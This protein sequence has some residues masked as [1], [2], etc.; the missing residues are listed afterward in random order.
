MGLT[1]FELGEIIGLSAYTISTWERGHHIPIKH[2]D[3]LSKAFNLPI[4]AI[5]WDVSSDHREINYIEDPSCFKAGKDIRPQIECF[6]GN[7]DFWRVSS[8]IMLRCAC[9]TADKYGLLTGRNYLCTHWYN[10]GLSYS[11]VLSVLPDDGVVWKN[12]MS[13][14]I[15]RGI[16]TEQVCTELGID[17][18]VWE[19]YEKGLR[20]IPLKHLALFSDLCGISADRLV[21]KK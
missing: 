10:K 11:D 6:C 1:R 4:E 18:S 14:R 13:A 15:L 12:L 2:Y 3:R 20:A 8:G 7:C 9:K 21:K 19:Q 5:V 17:K 16:S